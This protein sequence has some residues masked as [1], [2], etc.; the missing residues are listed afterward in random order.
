MV[1]LINLFHGYVHTLVRACDGNLVG[2]TVIV[3]V[4]EREEEE[5]KKMMMMNCKMIDDG[6]HH[7]SDRSG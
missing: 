1:K 7:H 6:I 2:L 4:G 5:T 3:F